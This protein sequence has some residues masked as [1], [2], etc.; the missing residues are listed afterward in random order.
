MSIKIMTRVWESKLPK[1]EK[2]ILLAYAD[3]AN[4]EGENVYPSIGRVAWKCGYST[5][6]VQRVTRSLV[7]QGI[8]E[9]KGK[10][11]KTRSGWTNRY[12]IHVG[13]L[14]TRPDYGEPR[15]DALSPLESEGVTSVQQGVTPTHEGVTSTTAR[16][17]IEDTRSI[18]DPL[19]YPLVES[20]EAQPSLQD[21]P[22]TDNP[23]SASNSLTLSQR[24]VKD[25]LDMA[26][27]C[28]EARAESPGLQTTPRVPGGADDP[29]ADG[30]LRAYCALVDVA[31]HR[32]SPSWPGELCRVA[33]L[34]GCGPREMELALKAWAA[35][36]AGA[37]VGVEGWWRRDIAA[38]FLFQ[39]DK[40]NDKGFSMDIAPLLDRALDEGRE[41]WNFPTSGTSADPPPPDGYD[42]WDEAQAEG[43]GVSVER[44]REMK[45]EAG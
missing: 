7:D 29:W 4:D 17:D 22:P 36:K 30:P 15:D 12:K 33:E 37:D 31:P 11:I 43:A 28:E 21:F 10:G 32:A 3:W 18:R 20:L 6:H 1:D 25:H 41:W 23:L 35:A 14:P 24:E 38:S 42:S 26:R 19:D 45:A 2:F 34:R 40:N 13:N 5:R 27:R 9:H 44:W 16:G 39:H 8:M